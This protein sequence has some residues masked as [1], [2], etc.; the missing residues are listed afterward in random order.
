MSNDQKA[1]LDEI[2]I[3]LEPMSKE[4]PIAYMM[5]ALVVLEAVKRCA[6]RSANG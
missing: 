6:G 5:V 2:R 1:L 3:G 4:D